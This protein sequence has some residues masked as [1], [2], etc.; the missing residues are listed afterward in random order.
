LFYSGGL[1]KS[2]KFLRFKTH[3]VGGVFQIGAGIHHML[4]DGA[5][6]LMKFI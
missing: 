4:D 2:Q 3:T 1:P 6:K 5:T